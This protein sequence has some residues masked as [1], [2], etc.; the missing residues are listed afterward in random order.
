MLRG[1]GALLLTAA[2]LMSGVAAAGKLR[3]Q[4]RELE[5]LAQAMAL[6]A[7]ELEGFQLPLPELCAGLART[8]AGAGGELFRRL[9]GLLDR[10]SEERFSGLWEEA[11]APLSPAARQCLMPLG[12][13]LGR[14][15]AAEQAG[16]V[17]HCRQQLLLQAARAEEL[18]RR[19]GRLYIGLS[20]CLGAALAVMLL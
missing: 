6:M 20:A 15:G 5:E 19:N 8:A 18:S 14:Y 13:V 16:A 11:A 12:C 4:H 3:R 7:L 17:R 10:L 2:G 1:L 9:E